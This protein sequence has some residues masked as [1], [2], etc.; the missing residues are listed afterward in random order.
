MRD[1]RGDAFPTLPNEWSDQDG[2]GYGDNI[3]DDFP[4]EATQWSDFDEDGYGDN[5]T[6]GAFKPDDC[7]EDSGTSYRDVYGCPDFDKDGTSDTT[8]PCPYDP[9]IFEGRIGSVVCKITE[10]QQSGESDSESASSST[11]PTLVIMGVAILILL[12]VIIVAQFSKT[13]AKNK[14][15]KE[16]ID[17]AMVNSAFSEEDERRTAWI[18]YYVANG[19]LD[20]AR[21][22]GW[23]G[24]EPAEMP[25]WKEFEIQQQKAQDEAIPNMVNLDDIL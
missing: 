14:S 9:D 6:G 22:L 20:E 24:G 19:Q 10:P 25:Q 8:D 1:Q 3:S 16:R 15:R 2:D 7:I 12:S 13:L 5:F 21:A 11:E 17:E 18:D 4:L 23:V